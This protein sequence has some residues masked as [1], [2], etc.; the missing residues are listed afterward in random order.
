MFTLPCAVDK[1]VLVSHLCSVLKIQSRIHL[2]KATGRMGDMCDYYG[3]VSSVLNTVRSLSSIAIDLQ[4]LCPLLGCEKIFLSARHDV[5][6]V[7]MALAVMAYDTPCAENFCWD[8][9]EERWWTLGM[10]YFE[11]RQELLNRTIRLRSLLS[12]NL[13]T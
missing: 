10:N 7:E 8:P 12:D 11:S 1:C 3:L 13:E 6:L 5:K 2:V 9:V 4:S